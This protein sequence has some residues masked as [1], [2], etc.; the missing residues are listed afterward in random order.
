MV[1]ED[2]I[3][4]IFDD[5]EDF[6]EKQSVEEKT[7]R[8]RD[9]YED[10]GNEL[11]EENNGL[12]KTPSTAEDLSNTFN[13][14]SDM[15]IEYEPQCHLIL[16]MEITKH[17]PTHNN[18]RTSGE[19]AICMLDYDIGQVVVCSKR[20]SHAFHQD[21]ILNW[22]SRAKTQCPSCREIFWDPNDEYK[23]GKK[24]NSLGDNSGSHA[25]HVG[26]L[27][28]NRA[29]ADT[30]D[31]D[32]LSVMGSDSRGNNQSFDGDGID[33]N[34]ITLEPVIE[35]IERESSTAAAAVQEVIA[36]A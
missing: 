20:C 9:H 25:D 13:N 15:M 1:T 16:P 36:S 31:T 24:K 28:G 19:C 23:D 4:W 5:D 30:D 17:Y 12:D 18:G 26:L 7:N 33:G 14:Y 3:E 35:H 29:R 32:V 6:N 22:F 8:S 27:G 2:H 34:G 10:T 11:N 21:C